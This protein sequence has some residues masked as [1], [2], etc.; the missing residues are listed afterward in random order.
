MKV[1]LLPF[2]ILI[3]I[4][5]S[6][7]PAAE[8]A[9]ILEAAQHANIP[10]IQRFIEHDPTSVKQID[11]YGYTPLRLAIFKGNY[12]V[13]QFLLAHDAPVNEETLPYEPPL[14]DACWLGDYKM[15]QLLLEYG[16]SVN[17]KDRLGR[18]PMHYA[19]D[20]RDSDGGMEIVKLLLKHNA[21]VNLSDQLGRLPEHYSLMNGN[22]A[23]TQLIQQWPHIL[24]NMHF[25]A[26]L[27]F[28]QAGHQHLGANSHA[29]ALPKELFQ[30]ILKHVK[31]EDFASIAPLPHRSFYNFFSKPW[32]RASARVVAESLIII[33]GVVLFNLFMNPRYAK[34]KNR[35]FG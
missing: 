11:N 20:T 9:T 1:I 24:Q 30:E 12:L 35:I 19:V 7:L 15:A 17:L 29:N 31:P 4:T 6:V 34:Y 2:S 22:G 14:H 32:V 23:I 13:A 25:Q 28:C 26:K 16:A 3:T 10:A 18:T 8:P 21:S 5:M 27:A 33:M